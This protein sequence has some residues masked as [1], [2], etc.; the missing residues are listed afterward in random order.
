MVWS[1]AEPNASSQLPQQYPMVPRED[2]IIRK[3]YQ[4]LNVR[5]IKREDSRCCGHLAFSNLK[6]GWALFGLVADS[7]SESPH[8][9][10]C[11]RP[12]VGLEELHAQ[13]D[14]SGGS[15]KTK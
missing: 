4:D 14:E 10:S 9:K 6:D 13:P 2:S 5:D 15:S 3:V 8:L 11:W 12:P 1:E 7:Q